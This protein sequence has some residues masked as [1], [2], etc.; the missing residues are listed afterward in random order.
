MSDTFIVYVSDKAP[1]QEPNVVRDIA[2]SSSRNNMTEGVSGILMGVGDKF[3]QVLEGK[4]E[5]V[6]QLLKKIERDPRHTNLKVLYQGNLN[7]RVFARWSMG[8]VVGG[9]GSADGQLY[10][11]DIA[12]KLESI[13]SDP[14]HGK[15][16]EQIKDL[17]IEIPKRI[18]ENQLSVG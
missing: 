13:C 4:A 1:N 15:L 16:G 17:L 2:I 6:D 8:C 3:L 18:A 11:D 14:E 9:E 12:S 5:T 7:E 10:L